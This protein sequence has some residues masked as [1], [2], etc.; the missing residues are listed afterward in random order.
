[1]HFEVRVSNSHLFS[2]GTEVAINSQFVKEGFS[3]SSQFSFIWQI[4]F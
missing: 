1:M 2:E 4:F 3:S